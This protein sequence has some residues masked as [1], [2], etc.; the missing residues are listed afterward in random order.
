METAA[1]N[2]VVIDAGNSEEFRIDSSEL[3]DAA[4]KVNAALDSLGRQTSEYKLNLNR[5]LRS[6]VRYR[7]GSDSLKLSFAG[8]FQR[9]SGQK[10]LTLRPLTIV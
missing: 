9:R 6:S 7:C 10:F 4:E 3:S 2:S 1:S 8:I 5:S